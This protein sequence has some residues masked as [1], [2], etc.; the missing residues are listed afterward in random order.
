MMLYNDDKIHVLDKQKHKNIKML[1][2]TNYDFA[3][4]VNSLPIAGVEFIQASKEYPIVFLKDD[5]GGFFPA[6]VLGLEDNRNVFVDADGNWSGRYIPAYVRR[7]PFVPSAAGDQ[8]RLNVCIDESYPGFNED[9]GDPLFNEDGSPATAL[10]NAVNLIQDYHVR[11]QHTINFT[12]RLA[13][14]GILQDMKAEF[15]LKGQERKVQLNGLYMVNEQELLKMEEAKVLDFF[16]K[17]EFAWIYSHLNS[18]SN[19]PQL[20]EKYVSD[21]RMSVWA[22]D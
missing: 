4:G 1:Q 6:V 20:A 12:E 10:Q 18:L 14:T 9:K 2:V 8:E 11:I 3:R 5:K 15:G 17:G 22:A 21:K 16:R 13:A 19:F 7:Y